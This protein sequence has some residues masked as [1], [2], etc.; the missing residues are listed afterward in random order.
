MLNLAVEQAQKELDDTTLTAPFDG[1]VLE[2]LVRPGESLFAGQ[3][4]V[5]LSD[6]TAGEV[7][8]TVIEEDLSLVTIGQPAEIF[9]DARPDVVVTGAVDRIVP[10]R[11]AGEARP[12]YHV[13]LTL[14]TELPNGVFPGM[15][16]DASIVIDEV[17]NVLRLPRA[18]VQARGD[19]T[20]VLQLWQ[21]NQTTPRDIQIGL[22]GDIYIEIVDG[23][24]VG[25][26]VIAE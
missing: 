25:D 19:G 1:V 3:A 2:V 16:A 11:V 23:V 6:P 14:S 18:L 12:L 8:T 20:A 13:Y 7:R 22:R 4:V 26:A 9:F 21:N 17:T 24:A 5:L 10:Q 15:T